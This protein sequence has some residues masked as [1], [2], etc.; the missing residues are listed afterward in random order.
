MRLYITN[1]G[2]FHECI[3]KGQANN[4]YIKLDNNNFKCEFC[5]SK[6]IP[7]I[8]ALPFRVSKRYSLNIPKTT[9]YIGE[10]SYIYYF[11]KKYSNTLRYIDI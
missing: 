6:E 3:C 9:Y 2:L 1:N 10:I 7:S 4:A 11:D 8:L 5:N